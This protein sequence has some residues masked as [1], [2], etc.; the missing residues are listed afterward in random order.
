MKIFEWESGGGD[1]EYT[2]HCIRLERGW[3][4]YHQSRD[5]DWYCTCYFPKWWP[6]DDCL[7]MGTVASYCSQVGGQRFVNEGSVRRRWFFKRTS[8]YGGLD[9]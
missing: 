2:H 7:E 6:D 5:T 1:R 4:E 8:Q 3:V 9:V